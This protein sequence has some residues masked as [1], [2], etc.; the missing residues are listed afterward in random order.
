MTLTALTASKWGRKGPLCGK[1]AW[2][3]VFCRLSLNKCTCT[4]TQVHTDTWGG[5]AWEQGVRGTFAFNFWIFWIFWWMFYSFEKLIAR[6][7]PHKLLTLL[8][9]PLPVTKSRLLSR[10]PSPT[11]PRTVVLKARVPGW[12]CRSEQTA[13]PQVTASYGLTARNQRLRVTLLQ[14]GFFRHQVWE[15]DVW[16]GREP[17][18]TWFP[19]SALPV[20]G[21]KGLHSTIRDRR[22][23]MQIHR[24]AHKPLWKSFHLGV[25]YFHLL[26]ALG[27][28]GGGREGVG[29]GEERKPVWA[30]QPVGP[31]RAGGGWYQG[32]RLEGPP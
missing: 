1:K 4:C 28:S 7:S 23:K 19:L 2:T 17:L 11:T 24:G 27:R 25:N 6:F 26:P 16:R 3:R 5:G 29:G 12:A 22:F 10:P 14:L 9:S 18:F 21:D 31:R 30:P 8:R 13:G 20:R 32:W 15:V